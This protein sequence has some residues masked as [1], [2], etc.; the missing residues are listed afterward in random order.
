VTPAP[1]AHRIEGVLFVFGV[2]ISTSDGHLVALGARGTLPQGP[3]TGAEAVAWG[4]GEGAFL[5]L[6]HPV[7][8]KNPWKDPVSGARVPGFELYSADTLFRD[9]L[10]RPFSRLLPAAFGWLG[11]RRH[12]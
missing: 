6:A 1:A 3:R 4:E 12:G 10:A 7:Q 9:A 5:S 2:E 11:G 8:K